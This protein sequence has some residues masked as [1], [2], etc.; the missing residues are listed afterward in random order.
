[1]TVLGEKGS[2]RTTRRREKRRARL[3]AIVTTDPPF[4]RHLLPV[5]IHRRDASIE[6]AQ[7]FRPA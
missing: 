5:E 7:V 6:V 3:S 4:A 2:R 1:V